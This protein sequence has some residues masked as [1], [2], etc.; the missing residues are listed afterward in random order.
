M[1][2]RH[3]FKPAGDRQELQWI[4]SLEPSWWGIGLTFQPTIIT[5]QLYFTDFYICS[6]KE[7]LA[8]AK[9]CQRFMVWATQDMWKILKH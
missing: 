7:E 2:F 5:S 3:N 6:A 8:A 9:D 4:A 1:C